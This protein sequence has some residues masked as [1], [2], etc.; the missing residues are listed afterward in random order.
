MVANRFEILDESALGGM[1][2][3][4]RAWDR[5]TGMHVAVKRLRTPTA[6]HIERF[7]REASVLRGLDHP[8]IVAY[9]AEGESTDGEY[10]L[11]MEWLE[12]EDLA[13]R[14]LRHTRLGIGECLSMA[15]RLTD[16]L[17]A[18][19][20]QG[21][22]HRDLKPSN[23]FL[24]AGRVDRVKML[25]FGL[26]RFMGASNVLTRTGMAVGTPADMAPEQVLA[27]AH[28][29]TRAD[30][31][32]LGCVLYECLTGEPPF[33][34][35][36]VSSVFLKIL[37][38]TPRSPRQLRP[39]IPPQLDALVASM[40][41]KKPDERPRDGAEALE[42]LRALDKTS[43]FPT[44][45][46]PTIGRSEQRIMAFIMAVPDAFGDMDN[47]SPTLSAARADAP[48]AVREVVDSAGGFCL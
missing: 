15:L 20:E 36:Q 27:D 11:V 33:Q 5:W 44:A 8:A 9:I 17:G 19:H 29:D 14:L 25:D 3:V 31:W 28:V 22:I 38:E 24:E 37:H 34:G 10:Y 46:A 4:H 26:A 30:V 32:S 39:E 42:Q 43:A 48:K 12:G 16:A 6:D 23:L 1:A 13:T 21:I 40:L 35:E 18:A 45:V 7:R 41:L 2:E 47:V